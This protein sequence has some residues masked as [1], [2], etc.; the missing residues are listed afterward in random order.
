MFSSTPSM[1]ITVIVTMIILTVGIFAFYTVLNEVNES[2]LNTTNE[3]DMNNTTEQIE[4]IDKNFSIVMD[5]IPVVLVV[6]AVMV[7]VSVVGG[8]FTGPHTTTYSS[9]QITHSDVEETQKETR[10]Q[11][12]SVPQMRG[13]Y[14]LY[15]VTDVDDA[16]EVAKR[17]RD[18]K[19]WTK[20]AKYTDKKYHLS[21]DKNCAV[22][23][24]NWSKDDTIDR[25]RPKWT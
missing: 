19:Y 23:V 11:Y 4:L 3:E 6:G 5:I 2:L 13:D 17:L 18:S 12:P 24:S 7:V 16:L 20:L 1:F 25:G 15:K 8:I 21:A 22:Y 9:P 14:Q 10:P